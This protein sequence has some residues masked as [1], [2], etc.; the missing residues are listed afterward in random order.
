MPASAVGHMM[1]RV[2]SCRR[3]RN[4]YAF[5][6]S[7]LLVSVMF[8][9]LRSNVEGAAVVCAAAVDAKHARRANTAIANICFL[10]EAA[11]GNFFTVR[12]LA[13][14]RLQGAHHCAPLLCN[15]QPMQSGGCASCVVGASRTRT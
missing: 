1:S 15:F 3:P 12:P 8:P 2:S 4:M 13:V 9:R 14:H 6:K 5:T 11:R 7:K 10:L